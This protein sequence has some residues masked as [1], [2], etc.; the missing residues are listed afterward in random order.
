MASV[1]ESH[2]TK[3]QSPDFRPPC[4]PHFTTVEPDGGK[5]ANGGPPSERGPEILSTRDTVCGVAGDLEQ[6]GTGTPPAPIFLC[7]RATF[8]GGAQ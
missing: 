6:A 2:Q 4:C 5:P 7:P 8:A 1:A 3:K